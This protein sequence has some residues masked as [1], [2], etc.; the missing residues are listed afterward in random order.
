MISGE[1]EN[2]ELAPES[3]RNVK[4]IHTEIHKLRFNVPLRTYS[5]TDN[6]SVWFFSDVYI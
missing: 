2:G 6:Q 3:I 5:Q 1:D 4:T